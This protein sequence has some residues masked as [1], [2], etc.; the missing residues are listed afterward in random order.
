[1]VFSNLRGTSLNI[2]ITAA[3]GAGFLL[4]GY[5]QG[6]FGGILTNNNFL[7]LF[8]HPG[9][10]L[11]GQI[12]ALYDIGCILGCLLS[13]F[14]GDM[15][16]RR[17]AILVGCTIL[18]VGAV[19]QTTAY[20]TAQMI[21]G[22]IV[23][24]IGNGLNTTAIPIWQV[25][26]AK[27]SHRGALIVFQLVTVIFGVSLTNWMNY[28]FTY[29]PNSEISWRFPLAF[30]I[31]FALVTIFLVS[32]LPESPRWLILK[33]RTQKAAEIIAH[34]RDKPNNDPE[35]LAEVQMLAENVAH[36]AADQSIPFREVFRNGRQQTLRR[37]LLGMGTQFMQQVGGTNVVA[38][39]M[40]VVLTRSFGMSERLSL[41]LSAT[42]SMWLM[43]WGALCAVFIDSVGR[44]RLMTWGAF[45]ESIC[46]AMIAAG[47]AVGGKA[48]L[49]VAVVFIYLYYTFYGLSFL[50][51]PFMYPAEINSQR[52]RNIG[53]SFSTLTNW[54]L[55][56]VVVS[57][58]PTGIANLGWKYYLIY[59]ITN[60]CFVPLVH[61]FYVETARLSLEEIDRVFE[62]KYEGGSGTTYEE[63]ARLARAW[64]PS[65]SKKT[66]TG[67]E[68]DHVEVADVEK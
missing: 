33:N 61:F 9:P 19:I 4:F 50:S 22:R 45:F 51:I 16:G 56:Y 15:L 60:M 10:T 30:Q 59:A 35:I 27:T 52:M 28:G 11:Q 57:I 67:V 65:D 48:M 13:M 40:P 68:V 64:R 31:F 3:S 1:M 49:I 2:A 20:R 62:F 32:F 23:A 63:A 39:Y 7:D 25:E 42:V 36:E 6:I 44:K 5:D 38:T 17:R 54:C 34:L 43:I 55:C 66:G 21:A 12:V 41:I 29:L 14:V 26:T 18:I 46:F 24:G 47:L 37:I 53:T 8:G 58:T